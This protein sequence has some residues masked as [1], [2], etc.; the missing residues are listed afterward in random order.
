MVALVF[1]WYL[2]N[3]GHVTTCLDLQK[4]AFYSIETSK[5]IADIT[6]TCV[7]YVEH[8]YIADHNMSEGGDSDGFCD[9]PWLSEI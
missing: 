4:H 2:Q 6:K 5:V 7:Q 3:E 1:A 8:I 9:I